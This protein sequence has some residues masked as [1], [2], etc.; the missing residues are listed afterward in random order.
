MLSGLGAVWQ[1]FLGFAVYEV[2]G[3]IRIPCH[4][5]TFRIGPYVVPS[6]RTSS[7]LFFRPMSYQDSSLFSSAL[8]FHCVSVFVDVDKLRTC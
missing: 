4:A 8:L 2:L 5:L 7:P 6:E 1:S 3:K